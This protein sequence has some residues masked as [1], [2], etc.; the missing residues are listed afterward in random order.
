VAFCYPQALY[1]TEPDKV[2]YPRIRKSALKH[3]G[4]RR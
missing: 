2:P 4:L 1:F 3:A